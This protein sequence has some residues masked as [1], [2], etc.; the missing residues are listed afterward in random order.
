[1]SGS[2]VAVVGAGQ[3]GYQVAASLREGGFDGQVMLIGDEPALPYQRPPLSKGYLTGEVARDGL[4]LRPRAFYADHRIELLEGE[5]VTAIARAERRLHLASGAAVP[6]DHLVLAT[7]ARD[8]RLRVPGAEL[9]GVLPLRTLGDAE[10]IR[11]RL[12]GAREIVIVGAGFIGLELAA[13]A[14]KLGARVHV[15]E[16]AQRAMGRAVSA[17]ISAYFTEAHAKSG[18]SILFG[19]AI[20]RVRGGGGRATGIETADGLR[21]PA[22][23]VLVGIGVRPNTE[24]AAAAGLPVDDGILV[25]EQ[26]RTPDEAVSA[27][28]DCAAYPSRFAGGRRVRLESVQN[29]VD[30]A[31]CVAA[32]LTG[33]PAPYRSVPWF[34]SEQGELRLQM[35]GLTAGYDTAVVRGDAAGGRFSVFC[36]RG[37]RL[38]GIESVN[39]PADHMVGRR[40]LA[41][42]AALSPQQAADEGF[43]LKAHA[44]AQ[45]RPV[46]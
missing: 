26:L 39:S 25:D 9:D 13:V 40:L 24:L 44:A 12:H 18:T 32:R 1:M 37:A 10:R 21:L 28:G 17:E 27:I 6:Y 20:A 19:A 36:F 11:E 46:A 35:V 23:L 42:E 2:T 38:L 8:R 43:D 14:A 29:A 31:R 15:L 34:W 3:G 4:S 33:R 5:L 30:Q 22:D 16:I 45:R 41:G 7:G